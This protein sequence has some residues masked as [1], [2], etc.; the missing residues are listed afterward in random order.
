M[1][2]RWRKIE[3]P[4]GDDFINEDWGKVPE[5]EIDIVRLRATG[6]ALHKMYMVRFSPKDFIA[7]DWQL[8]E[9]YKSEDIDAQPDRVGGEEAIGLWT[10]LN[11][12]TGRA[13]ESSTAG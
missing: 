13:I 10:K 8:A 11:K 6:E 4:F 7:S 2:T 12:R 1:I 9:I 5:G 3:G